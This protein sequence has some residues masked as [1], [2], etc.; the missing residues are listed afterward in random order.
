MRILFVMPPSPGAGVQRICETL[1]ALNEMEKEPHS[2]TVICREGTFVGSYMHTILCEVNVTKSEPTS[3]RMKA[4]LHAAFGGMS[5]RYDYIRGIKKILQSDAF[6]C[7]VLENCPEL[8]STLRSLTKQEVVLHSHDHFFGSDRKNWRSCLRHIRRFVFVSDFLKNAAI[9][10]GVPAD[11]CT[12]LYDCVDT[13]QFDASLYTDIRKEKRAKYGLGDE[14][15]LGIFV[16]LLTPEKGAL[17]LT[18]AMAHTEFAKAKCKLLLVGSAQ[19]GEDVRDEYR[20]QLEAAAPEGRVVFIGSVKPSSTARFFARADFAV[21]P[22]VF[23]EPAGLP[24]LEAL[25]CGLPLIVSDAGGIGEYAC[26]DAV[27]IVSRGLGYV[28]SLSRAMD[29]L[30]DRLQ[31]DEERAKLSTAAREQAMRFDAK[32]YLERFLKALK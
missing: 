30:C 29:T 17:E 26:G 8:A 10:C 9:R 4:A 25:A 18:K 1:F 24:V 5:K 12:T 14:D 23:D 31:N 7:V 22:S 13:E 27:T 21:V 11:R 15:L 28:A 20:D 2:F 6:D 3:N 32:G 19:Y 16:G